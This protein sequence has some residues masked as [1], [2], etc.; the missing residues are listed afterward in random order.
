MLSEVHRLQ[1]LA[2]HHPSQFA[3]KL[4]VPGLDIERILDAAPGDEIGRG[5]FDH[6]ESS[7]A[8]AVNAFGF[9]LHRASELPPLPGC[10]DAGWPARSLAIE[11]TVRFPWSGGRHPA[12]DCLVATPSALI[13]IESK[14]FESF[15]GHAAAAFREAYWR[16]VWGDRMKGHEQVRD[17]LRDDPHRYCRLDAAQLVKHAFGL[18]SEVHRAGAHRGLKPIIFYVHAEPEY[19]LRT[20][21]RV[22]DAAKVVHRDEIARFARLVAGDEVAFVSCTWQC[23]LKAWRRDRREKIRTHAQAVL[24]R[25]SP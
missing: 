21:R 14:R 22:D 5:K 15:R 20:G 7:A 13:G 24:A 10:P 19:W 8:L 18:R 6:P 9:F 25:Y 17:S 1:Q 2:K 11:A 12:L 23:L 4:G 3:A 16:P